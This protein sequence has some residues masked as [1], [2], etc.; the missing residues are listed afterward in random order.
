MKTVIAMTCGILAAVGA[1]PRAHAA[2][3]M[4]MGR[5]GGCVTLQQAA[6]QEPLLAG[7]ETPD[8]LIARLRREGEGF[9]RQDIEQGGVAVVQID[10][11][12]RELGLIFVPPSLCR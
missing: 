7:I 8:Q 4:L 2:E 6:A 10:V 9:Q 11:P 3:W 1:V 12:G 5:E